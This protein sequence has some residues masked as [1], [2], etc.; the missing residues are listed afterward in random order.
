MTNNQ[1]YCP[2]GFSELSHIGYTRRE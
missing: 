2:V 1:L